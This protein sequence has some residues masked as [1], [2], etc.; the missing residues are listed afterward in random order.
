VIKKTLEILA[1]GIFLA[2]GVFGVVTVMVAMAAYGN[3]LANSL[4]VQ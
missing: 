1:L 4:G 2:I 3:W